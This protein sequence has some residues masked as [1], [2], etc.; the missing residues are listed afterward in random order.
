MNIELRNLYDESGVIFLPKGKNRDPAVE[1][2]QAE[3]ID[4][5]GFAGRCL[6]G[7]RRR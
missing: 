7:P 4:P 5:P 2:L 1:A 6:H 3:G